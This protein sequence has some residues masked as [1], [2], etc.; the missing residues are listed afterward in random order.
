[1][2]FHHI[3][4]HLADHLQKLAKELGVKIHTNSNIEKIV[5]ENGS[6]NAIIINGESIKGDI[7]LSGADYHH[8]ESLLDQEYRGYSEKYWENRTFAPSSAAWKLVA[9]EQ[10]FL[11]RRVTSR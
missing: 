4:F 6:A 11:V 5:V 8:S 1:M 3:G 7:I 2:G 10:Q 9:A